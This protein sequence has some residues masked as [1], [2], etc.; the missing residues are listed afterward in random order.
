MGGPTGQIFN[1]LFDLLGLSGGGEPASSHGDPINVATGNMWHAST[2]MTVATRG[3]PV[4]WTRTYN[5]QSDYN[6][7]LGHVSTR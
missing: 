4:D 2:D 1:W 3:F 7:P 5:S 6:G